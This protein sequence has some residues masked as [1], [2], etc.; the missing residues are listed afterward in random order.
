MCTGVYN[1]ELG[2]FMFGGYGHRSDYNLA[3]LWFLSVN[4]SSAFDNPV[5]TSIYS[6]SKIEVCSNH[7]TTIHLH[8]IFMFVGWAVFL[9]IGII[10]SRYAD[11]ENET[12]HRLVKR[13]YRALQ[14]I[15]AS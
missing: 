1:N 12:R 2:V 6:N 9:N 15:F 10:I 5:L 4:I 7:F 13:I 14:V 8:A 11:S 3:D